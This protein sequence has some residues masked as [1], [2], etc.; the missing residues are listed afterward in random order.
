M[1]TLPHATTA[2][3]NAFVRAL[4]R[5]FQFSARG[6]SFRT[7]VLAGLTTFSTFSYILVVNPLIMRNA[8]M[9]Y[10]ALIT[11]TALVAAIFT[12]IMGLRTNYPLAMA[13]GMG[14]NAYIAIQ[15]C[16][17]MHVPWQAAIGLIF[18]SGVLFF[19]ISV[20]GIRQKIIESFPP[21]FKK[22][23]SVGIGFFIAL[24][25]LKQAGILVA[26][27]KTMVSLGHFN[28]AGVLLAFAGIILLG[29][30]I[31]RRVP[32]AMVLSILALTLL[33]LVLPG[34]KPGTTI[35]TAPSHL[36]DWPASIA[37]LFL[38]LD[39]GYFWTHLS[40]SI[41][42][43]L[44]LVFSDL[45]SAMAVLVAVGTRANLNDANGN[46]PK[47][48]E[49]LSADAAASMTASLMGSNM[50]IIYLESTAGVEQGGARA[51]SVSSSRSAACSRSSSARS[52][53]SSP[54]WLPRRRWSPSASSCSRCSPT[55][56]CAISS[57]RPRR[58][59]A[60]SACAWPRSATALALGFLTWSLLNLG[61]GRPRAI[62]PIGYALV[63][64]LRHPLPLPVAIGQTYSTTQ[65]HAL[66]SSSR[67]WI[68]TSRNFP[69]VL[70]VG[71][72]MVARAQRDELAGAGQRQRDEELIRQVLADDRAGNLV[73]P[74]R[75]D[76]RLRDA[77]GRNALFPEAGDDFGDVLVALLQQDHIPRSGRVGEL[78][79]LERFLGPR[80]LRFQ[81]RDFALG[82]VLRQVGNIDE[83]AL[84]PQLALLEQRERRELERGLD[85]RME[86]SPTRRIKSG[87]V[88]FS[89]P[90]RPQPGERRREGAME[91]IEGWREGVECSSLADQRR[92]RRRGQ[93]RGKNRLE[94]QRGAAGRAH[95]EPIRAGL[96]Q[97]RR[98]RQ[99]LRADL[100]AGHGRMAHLLRRAHRGEMLPQQPGL[101]ASRANFRNPKRLARAKRE[102]QRRAQNLSPRLRPAS[103]RLG[104]CLSRSLQ[105]VVGVLDHEACVE[106]RDRA[107][108]PG[109]LDRAQHFL[110]V[111][112]R[113]G[114]L[115]DRV[116][117]AVGQNVR[118]PQTSDRRRPGRACAQRPCGPSRGPRRGSRCS[119]SSPRRP[120]RP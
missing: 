118:A 48:K 52:S 33:G 5:F 66:E 7:E 102:R 16:L 54:A 56:T 97:L 67:K 27:P 95:G 86:F 24:I 50:P 68:F 55:S 104:S 58:S 99:L 19:I 105:A 85:A 31:L 26:N 103:R 34:A 12:V 75:I 116:G 64:A 93:Q 15:V 89:I 41:P 113:S 76:R 42:I 71:E 9:D 77:L 57:P 53:P 94:N 14:G 3:G 70:G 22:I 29:I 112:V 18:Y 43:V 11:M 101:L 91:K 25:G 84:V 39:F 96:D 119:G 40:L 79:H 4:D 10:G 51:W 82:D 62:T 6:S 74:Q 46:L 108:E 35:T 63:R 69:I 98:E 21:S 81:V 117:A 60:S 23:I 92:G 90:A 61:L 73:T 1:T 28:T 17:G 111:L 36:F 88:I 13:P 109:G 8:G 83:R 107:G 110:E 45:F 114:R 106:S 44:T 78:K 2:G 30:M 65:R 20:T 37:P 59:L 32:G 49:A 115:V 120:P 100:R 47:Q 87:P 72:R 80:K 38:K